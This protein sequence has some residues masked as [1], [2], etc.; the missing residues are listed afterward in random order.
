MPKAKRLLLATGAAVASVSSK[1]QA[2]PSQIFYFYDVMF[3]STKSQLFLVV[4]L[5]ETLLH[6]SK[7]LTLNLSKI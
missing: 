5:A 3:L 6:Y 4:E 2:K 1:R 7:I